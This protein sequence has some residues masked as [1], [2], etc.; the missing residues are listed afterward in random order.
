[1]KIVE[2][3]IIEQT[4]VKDILCNK[5]GNSCFDVDKINFEGLI[6]AKVVGGYNSK[7]LGDM[8]SYTFSLCESCLWKLF[9][10]F[11]IKAYNDE[12]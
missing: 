12:E 5:C 11:C 4:Y 1:M 7:Y 6:E 3:K 8:C 2:K 10:D 9:K